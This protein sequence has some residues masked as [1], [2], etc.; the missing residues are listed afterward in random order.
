MNEDRDEHRPRNFEPSPEALQSQAASSADL[1]T[2]SG[3]LGKMLLSRRDLRR[4]RFKGGF[5]GCINSQ[6]RSR[7][8]SRKYLGFMRE[9]FLCASKIADQLGQVRVLGVL[10]AVVMLKAMSQG[11]STG[12]REYWEGVML[13]GRS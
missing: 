11:Y 7:C 5:S 9:K 12:Y 6:N 10:G 8:T 1:R 2:L 3:G 4:I 13:T